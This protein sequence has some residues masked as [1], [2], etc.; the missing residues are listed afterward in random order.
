MAWSESEDKTFVF[1]TLLAQMIH[2]SFHYNHSIFKESKASVGR[3]LK[4]LSGSLAG[5]SSPLKCSKRALHNNQSPYFISRYIL[6]LWE[7]L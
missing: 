3:G 7:S 2:E 1:G 5:L 6:S 4:N